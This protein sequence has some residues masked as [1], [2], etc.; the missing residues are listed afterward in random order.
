MST[1]RLLKWPCGSKGTS[2]MSFQ[3][4]SSLSFYKSIFL[5][6]LLI[7]PTYITSTNSQTSL[8]LW[9]FTSIL[10]L[11]MMNKYPIPKTVWLKY[12]RSITSNNFNYCKACSFFHRHCLF[13]VFLHCSKEVQS[14]LPV[15]CSTSWY[16]ATINMAWLALHSWWT[17]HIL[18][19]SQLLCTYLYVPLLLCGIFRAKVQEVYLLETALDNFANGSIH[20]N[21]HS[22]ISTLILWWLW[23]SMAILHLHRSSWGAVLCPVQWL[24]S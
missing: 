22:W 4:I 18:R 20:S 11:V 21:F 16:H 19:L 9:V 6:R 23:F 14:Y 17:C 15:A 10:L 2:E 7:Y 5:F 12:N 1:C 8:I 3:L 24:L 13:T